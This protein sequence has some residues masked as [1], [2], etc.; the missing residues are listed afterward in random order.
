MKIFLLLFLFVTAFLKLEAVES[1]TVWVKDM[2]Q[3]GETQVKDVRFSSDDRYAFV[4]G[5]KGIYMFETETGKFLKS[6]S[7]VKSFGLYVSFDV[8][9]DNTKIMAITDNGLAVIWDINTGDTVKSYKFPSWSNSITITPDNKKAFI[10]IFDDRITVFNLE[11]FTIDNYFNQDVSSEGVKVSKDGKYAAVICRTNTTWWVSIYD[12]VTYKF[13]NNYRHP[14][15]ITDLKFSNDGKYL[16]SSGENNT[17]MLW[18]LE[19]QKLLDTIKTDGYSDIWALAF[20]PNSKYLVFTIPSVIPFYTYIYKINEKKIVYKYNTAF[21]RLE[22]SANSNYLLGTD[23]R[24]VTLLNAHWQPNNVLSENVG[25]KSIIVSPNPTNGN[26]IIS[27]DIPITSIYNIVIN[28]DSGSNKFSEQNKFIEKGNYIL[29]WDTGT[30]PS[31]VY[32][33]RISAVGFQQTIKL[34]LAK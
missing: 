7:N 14:N 13:I 2:N 19:N 8:F 17:I 25:I 23:S 18:D 33:C 11:T 12:A 26:S 31:G 15:Q 1:D 34:I 9:Y 24:N 3:Y 29:N 16:A 21:T 22:S 30:I 6:F 5:S 10:N 27:L 4:L 20:S 28:D 32:F